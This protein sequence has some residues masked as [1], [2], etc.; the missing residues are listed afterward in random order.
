MEQSGLTVKDL[1]PIIG[2]SNRVDEVLGRKRKLTL[3]MIQ[4]LHQALHIPVEILIL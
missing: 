3:P 1:E 4:R 2:K